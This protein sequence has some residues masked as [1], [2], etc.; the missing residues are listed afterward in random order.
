MTA[1]RTPSL[2]F[3]ISVILSVLIS[4]NILSAENTALQKPAIYQGNE[5]ITGWFMSEKLDGIRGYW[6]GKQLLTRK[7]KAIYPPAWFTQNFPPFELD[8][9]LWSRQNQFEFIQSTVLDKTPSDDWKK[10]TY[11][12]FEVPNAIGDFPTRLQKAR[13]WFSKHS[14][15]YV[16]IIPQIPCKGKAHLAKFLKQ[17][18]SKGGEGVIVKDPNQPYHTG[19]SPH[20]LKVKNFSDMEGTVMAI[21]PGKGKFK[22]MM[23][24]LTVKLQNGIQFK[25]GSGFS[26][27]ERV[28]PP[29]VGEVITFKHYGFT[30]NGKPKFASFMRLRKD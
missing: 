21:Q 11:N 30:K 8:G 20:V 4:S 9:E 5:A 13:D 27:K 3:Y 15:P 6:D 16:R 10:I 18:E 1:S 23:G 25:I 22:G 26:K 2:F 24:S 14:N 29:K 19:R 28:S 12:L 17:I 7:G